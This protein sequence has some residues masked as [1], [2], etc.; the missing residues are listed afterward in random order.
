MADD[1]RSTINVAIRRSSKSPAIFLAASFTEPAWE[2]VELDVKPLP[3][4]A[5]QDT[6]EQTN[7]HVP[8]TQYEFSKSFEVALGKHHYKFREGLEGAWFYDKDVESAVDNEGN[9]N[10]VLVVEP[11]TATKKPTDSPEKEDAEEVSNEGVAPDAGKA[12]EVELAEGENISDAKKPNDASVE[13]SPSIAVVGEDVKDIKD[14]EAPAESLG[15]LEIVGNKPD[16]EPSLADTTIKPDVPKTDA[17]ETPTTENVAPEKVVADHGQPTTP[18]QD[19]EIVDDSPTTA[20]I[21]GSRAET[22]PKP[23][24]E[25]C[26]APVEKP[27]EPVTDPTSEPE[28][29]E[30]SILENEPEHP[31]MENN[32][33]QAT[34]PAEKDGPTA[35]DADTTA[36]PMETELVADKGTGSDDPSP[37]PEPT[38]TPEPTLQEVVTESAVE[39]NAPEVEKPLAI[40]K[41]EPAK[42]NSQQTE[43]TSDIEPQEAEQKTVEPSVEPDMSTSDEVPDSALPPAKEPEEPMEPVPTE[44]AQSVEP[45]TTVDTPADPEPSHAEVVVAEEIP[46]MNGDD[47]KEMA[48]D[49]QV[50]DKPSIQQLPETTSKAGIAEPDTTPDTISENKTEEPVVPAPVETTSPESE[51]LASKEEDSQAEN[52]ADGAES[53]EAQADKGEMVETGE[54]TVEVAE[55]I[56]EAAADDVIP[57]QP[58]EDSADLEQQKAEEPL[59]L[60]TD[61]PKESKSESSKPVIEDVAAKSVDDGTGDTPI[62]EEAS[63]AEPATAYPDTPVVSEATPGQEVTSTPEV[64]VTTETEEP[65]AFK[66]EEAVILEPESVEK[67]DDSSKPEEL[68]AAVVADESVAPKPAEE[69]VVTEPQDDIVAEPEPASQSDASSTAEPDTPVA[70]KEPE[71]PEPAEDTVPETEVDSGEKPVEPVAPVETPAAVTDE[72]ETSEPAV[73]VAEVESSAPVPETEV[74]DDHTP[75]KLVEQEASKSIDNADPTEDS[76]PDVAP[77]VA[78]ES[79][80]VEE[81]TATELSEDPEP[82]PADPAQGEPPTID[83]AE[84]GV[85]PTEPETSKPMDDLVLEPE[86]ALQTTSSGGLN[87]PVETAQPDKTKASDDTV[88]DPAELAEPAKPAEPVE[89]AEPELTTPEAPEASVK[90]MESETVQPVYDVASEAADIA[91]PAEPADAEPVTE[92]ETVETPDA[93]EDP[94]EP[95]VLEPAEDATAQQEPEPVAATATLDT[96]QAPEEPPHTETS[97]NADDTATQPAKS[98]PELASGASVSGIAE[99]PAE[100]VKPEASEAINNVVTEPEPIAEATS[101]DAPEVSAEPTAPEALLVADEAIVEPTAETEVDSTAPDS[102]K[103]V[104]AAAVELESTASEEEQEVIESED[105]PIAPAPETTPVDAPNASETSVAP[106]VPEEAE[107]DITT[108]TPLESN[109]PEEVTPVAE[110]NVDTPAS[111]QE[112]ETLEAREADVTNPASEPTTIDDSKAAEALAPA[113]EP[114]E[115]PEIPT[116]TEGPEA[117]KAT[118]DAVPDNAGEEVATNDNLADS[119]NAQPDT[120][121]PELPVTEERVEDVAKPVIADEPISDPEP[122]AAEQ[123][124]GPT[125]D[126]P[127]VA[128]AEAA[129]AVTEPETNEPNE[130]TE[131]AVEPENVEQEAVESEQPAV[132]SATP[133]EL[134]QQ[135]DALSEIAHDIPEPTAEKSSTDPEITP[136]AELVS[137]T[138]LASEPVTEHGPEVVAEPTTAVAVATETDAPASKDLEVPEKSEHVEISSVKPAGKEDGL[139]PPTGTTALGQSAAEIVADELEESSKSKDAPAAPSPDEVREPESQE[140]EVPKEIAV[141]IVQPASLNTSDYP[142]IETPIEGSTSEPVMADDNQAPVKEAP[143]ETQAKPELEVADA[144]SE[145]PRVE[146]N[147]ITS[148]T[149]LEDVPQEPVEE[150]AAAKVAAAALATAVV[151]AG[152]TQLVSNSKEPVAD[153][154]ISSLIGEAPAEVVASAVEAPSSSVPEATPSDKDMP[155]AKGDTDKAVVNGNKPAP[156]PEADVDAAERGFTPAKAQEEPLAKATE[157]VEPAKQSVAERS[158]KKPD[159]EAPVPTAASEAEPIPLESTEPEPASKPSESATADPTTTTTELSPALAA[160]KP[161]GSG[162]ADGSRPPTAGELSATSITI[163]KRENFF[164]AL[165]HAIFTSFFGGFFS[166]FRRGRRDTPRQALLVTVTVTIVPTL[167]AILLAFYWR[168]LSSYIAEYLLSVSSSSLI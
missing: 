69:P 30:K 75:E 22:S 141:E 129:A 57:T 131:T 145:E 31:Q 167:I 159:V 48:D 4:S 83:V 24:L 163:H 108:S 100:S 52:I 84:A 120:V 46:L 88:S 92:T 2:P 40:A 149:P 104:E 11:V 166:V 29:N 28:V 96:A 33:G 154:D 21:D 82:K 15:K 158:T 90:T 113:Q 168:A 101:L 49:E 41:D 144:P 70:I 155:S 142:L 134:P 164:K 80:T 91:E 105:N 67:Q 68:D 117:S 50:E 135:A 62:I 114:E 61:V 47:K 56:A 161:A 63:A 79:S 25:V 38:E 127:E 55:P 51:Q 6:T 36:E 97:V 160:T 156:V 72:P 99:A 39:E 109:V 116:P 93:P 13:P 122:I 14:D 162:G 130:V 111:A 119:K 1:T 152:V 5:S 123:P 23:V 18:A 128:P 103:T 32:G 153:K 43:A 95:E 37:A 89:P 126:E 140:P 157:P 10:N 150:P 44:P 73:D 74:V 59:S 66:P 34:E 94:K 19:T 137:E 71:A 143:P 53:Q 125:P 8:D 118:D 132:T 136:S 45:S 42:E 138:I 58:T 165:W 139:E 9:E 65:Q 26:E 20:K 102:Q 12:E 54:T 133:S 110:E 107:A 147:G 76:T 151:G 16:D 64:P 7:G 77:I 146:V 87:A 112:P 148:K 121:T 17:S 27:H 81:Q 86:P 3:P 106:A 98:E 115:T 124:D 60:A 35:S 85:Q 78:G